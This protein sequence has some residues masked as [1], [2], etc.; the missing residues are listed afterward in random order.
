MGADSAPL[1]WDDPDW[2]QDGT[3][4]NRLIKWFSNPNANAHALMQLKG[5]IVNGGLNLEVQFP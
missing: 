1:S 3:S 2:Y 5:A 4:L